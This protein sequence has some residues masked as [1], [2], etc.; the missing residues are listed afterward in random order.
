MVKR[1]ANDELSISHDVNPIVSLSRAVPAG[2]RTALHWHC[3]ARKYVDI[4]L[5]L[6]MA[7][8]RRLEQAVAVTLGLLIYLKCY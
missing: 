8:E 2:S 4:N 6:N 1:Y 5:E 7:S 3:I